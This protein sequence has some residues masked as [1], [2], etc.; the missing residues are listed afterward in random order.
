MEANSTEALPL[1]YGVSSGE[2]EVSSPIGFET[3]STDE[4]RS[5]FEG[6]A[7]ADAGAMT[8]LYDL[9]AGKLY[10]L[11]LW[12]TG[13]K[14]DAADVVH[15]VFVRLAEQRERLRRVREPKSWLLTVAR[16]LAIDR[17]RRRRRQ[18]AD[19]LDEHP[20]LE[21]PPHD[22]ERFV[23]ARRISRQLA[24]LPPAQREVIFLYHFS[25]L[26]FAAI[27]EITGVPTFTAASRY[28]LAIQK[29]R[30]RLEV[31]A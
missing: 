1:S 28:R 19:S 8:R 10:G 17:T 27:G 13:S 25:G 12:R 18:S 4:W 3:M 16:R 20:Y 24:V 30:R 14:E 21:A 23:E 7:S 2:R 15:D 11:A 22:A 31:Q 29:L 5:L 26:T 9:A 6:L